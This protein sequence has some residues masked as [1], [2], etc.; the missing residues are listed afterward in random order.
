MPTDWAALIKKFR[1]LRVLVVGDIILDRWCTYDPA[2]NAPSHQTGIPRLGIIRTDVAPGAG[3]AV[4]NNLAA[5]GAGRTSVLGVIGQDGFGFELERALS[6]RSIDYSLLVATP[7]LQT[8][9]FSRL[10]SSETGVE[11]KPRVDFLNRGPLPSEVEDQLIANFHLTYEKFDAI[12]ISD[13]QPKSG[14]GVITPAFREVLADVAERHNTI[15]VV[16]DSR[17]NLHLYRNVVAKAN[18]KEAENA[19]RELFD[20]IDFMRLRRTIGSQPLVITR[21]ESGAEIYTNEGVQRLTAIATGDP[22]DT[23]AAGEAFDAGIALALRAGARID[24]AV[25]FGTMVASVTIM[26]AGSGEA[27]AEEV[28]AVADTMTPR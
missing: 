22:V 19:S 2:E 5:L 14:G 18:A 10:I 24:D 4:A 27:S 11:D 7:D 8:S 6:K 21:G 25:R 28:L 1:N 26:K 20:E 23:C 16:G 9:V 13:H 12:I 3:G 15:T 17:S